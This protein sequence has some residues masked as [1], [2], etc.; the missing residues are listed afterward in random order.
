MGSFEDNN[1]DRVYIEQNID[2][3]SNEESFTDPPSKIIHT[4]QMAYG[5]PLKQKRQYNRWDIIQ[6]LANDK[7][8]HTGQGLTYW[9]LSKG[10]YKRYRL[11]QTDKQAQN[12]LRNLYNNKKL[13]TNYTMTIPQ[14]YFYTKDQAE[15][16]AIHNKKNTH[17]RPT[18]V[19]ASQLLKNTAY[20]AKN[21][22]DDINN[23]DDSDVAALE[24]AKYQ[25]DLKVKDAASTMF[26]IASGAIPAGLHKNHIHFE[27]N[28]PL[29]AEAYYERL[30]HIPASPTKSK[31]K[32][33]EC[34]IDNFLVRS[35][36][37][38]HGAVDIYIPCSTHPFPIHIHDPD[39]TNTNIISF[40]GQIR[41]FLCSSDGLKDY[42]GRIVPNIQQWRFVRADVN[43]DVPCTVQKYEITANI[44]LTKFGEVFRIYKKMIDGK[45]CLRVEQDKTFNA[46]LDGAGGGGEG[47]GK[48]LGSTI[49]SVAKELPRKLSTMTTI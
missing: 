5:K 6:S 40:A 42:S 17:P 44:Q 43:F 38:P 4:Q 8:V 16:S 33:I 30:A 35:F 19:N 11:V 41:Q 45:T 47:G 46:P 29:I 18:G 49:V 9:D 31:E 1:S 48:N 14:Q 3:I 24:Y 36:F 25:E 15:L 20:T 12:L 13:Y 26:L 22:N 39:T 7:F 21:Y 27:L 28:P 37:F 10:R 2:D 32:R 34:R 23:L